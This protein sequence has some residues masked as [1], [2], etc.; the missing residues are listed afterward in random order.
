MFR[1]HKEKV[2]TATIHSKWWQLSAR[3]RRTKIAL[4]FGG[5][6]YVI[7]AVSKLPP[8]IVLA[9]GRSAST[10]DAPYY[11]DIEMLQR[12]LSHGSL[13]VRQLSAA[14][15]ERIHV[16]DQ[17]GPAIHSVIELNPDALAIA[18]R[19]DPN[20][21]HGSLYGMPILI[22]DNIDTGDR[23]LTSVGSLAF[24]EAATRDAELV[25]R[26]RMAGA[27]IL[28]KTNPS[29]WVK[30]PLKPWNQCW[31][32]RGGQTHNP[33]VLPVLKQASLTTGI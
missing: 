6:L 14:F 9:N 19:L 25:A 13:S 22:K 5:L 11:D 21:V 16:L 30:L 27:V 10:G 24:T 4:L 15:V 23:M 12:E 26:V 20:P 1:T 33:Y 7:L 28:G 2:R 8:A 17:A 18:D 31:S 29:E 3:D 32:A